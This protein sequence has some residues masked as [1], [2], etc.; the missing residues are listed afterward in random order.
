MGLA[1][2]GGRGL[3][4]PSPSCCCNQVKPC[5]LLPPPTAGVQLFPCLGPL[6][7]THIGPG[8]TLL[9]LTLA[10]G[11]LP[12]CTGVQACSPLP[13]PWA[14]SP[15]LHVGPGPTPLPQHGPRF[16]PRPML[17]ARSRALCC[18]CLQGAGLRWGAE[19][20]CCGLATPC[21]IP[22][23]PTIMVVGC[24]LSECFFALQLADL[25][26]PSFASWTLYF[27]LCFISLRGFSN[28]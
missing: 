7:H 10:L 21:S 16:T 17:P 26:M 27:L 14:R 8:P 22:C 24:I 1:P 23:V 12:P 19:A 6:P 9:P 20:S 11:L 15:R 4:L 25:L 2:R 18:G 3:V 28:G 5:L 13:C